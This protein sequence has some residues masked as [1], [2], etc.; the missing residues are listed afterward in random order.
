MNEINQM[1]KLNPEQ[2]VA[3]QRYLSGRNFFLTG[4]AGTGK[5]FLL[6]AI[7]QHLRRTVEPHRIGICG[8]TGVSAI[9]INGRT[10]HSWAGIGLGQGSVETLYRKVRKNQECWARWSECRCLIIDEVSMM[11]LELFEKLHQLGV[12]IRKNTGLFGGM[13]VILAGDFLQ[14]PPIRGQFCFE[15]PLWKQA[16]DRYSGLIRSGTRNRVMYLHRIIRQEN[17]RFHALLSRVRLGMINQSDREILVSRKVAYDYNNLNDE[18]KTILPTRLYPYRKDVEL[19]NGLEMDRLLREGRKRME[20]IPT[21]SLSTTE[22]AHEMARNPM[23]MKRYRFLKSD[24]AHAKGTGFTKVME[25]LS[26]ADYNNAVSWC[27]GAQVMLTYNLDVERGLVNGS[28]GIVEVAAN[29]NG[30]PMVRFMIRESIKEENGIYRTDERY[31]VI[32]ISRVRYEIDHYYYKIIISQYPLMLAWAITIHRAQSATLDCVETDLSEVFSPGQT[33]VTL[34][35]V[36]DLENLYLLGI[37]FSKIRADQ[38]AVNYYN[39]LGVI[40]RSRLNENCIP[41]G[42]NMGHT[43]ICTSCL[44]YLLSRFVGTYLSD[45]ILFYL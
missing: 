5:S 19:I 31:E 28:R 30:N 27:V 24:I 33:Y 1:N 11:S 17:V 14:L 18:G 10:L 43:E 25:K 20:S 3:F 6:K 8:L 21:Y 29:E 34:S 36:R 26:P 23:E 13:Q 35:R 16:F 2:R 4:G 45:R 15:S 39:N 42:V 12:K 22:Y 32:E 38:Q 9:P 37:N 40:C 44:R 41:D 7:V